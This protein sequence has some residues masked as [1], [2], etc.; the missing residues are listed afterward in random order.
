MM[1]TRELHQWRKQLRT[2]WRPH[3]RRQTT[4]PL[5]HFRSTGKSK[6]EN[7]RYP[8]SRL[9][10]LVFTTTQ[11]LQSPHPQRQPSQ[12]QIN[13]LKEAHGVGDRTS[14]QSFNVKSES[15]FG[16][17]CKEMSVFTCS[18]NLM[19]IALP[20]F[21]STD[22]TLPRILRINANNHQSAFTKLFC[23]FAVRQNFPASPAL[24]NH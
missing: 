5:Q 11:I 4:L 18:I 23:V 7:S 21:R 15:L 14:K 8:S 1:E 3:P 22:G 10:R 2:R 6:S 9:V 20:R 16:H 12:L 24:M 19:T 17:S 13:S